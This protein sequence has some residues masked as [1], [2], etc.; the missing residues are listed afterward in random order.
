MIHLVEKIGLGI[1]VDYIKLLIENVKMRQL[2]Q[3]PLVPVCQ[4]IKDL[5]KKNKI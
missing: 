5:N 4:K 1:A 3:N 2:K